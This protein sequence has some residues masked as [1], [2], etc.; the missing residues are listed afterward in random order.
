MHRFHVA[1][2]NAEIYPSAAKISKQFEYA[3]KK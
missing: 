1:G 2:K 3:D